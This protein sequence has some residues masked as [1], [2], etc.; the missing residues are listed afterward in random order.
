MSLT[1]SANDFFA[2]HSSPRGTTF[3][4]KSRMTSSSVMAY[5]RCCRATEVQAGNS[6]EVM[7]SAID[8]VAP[9]ASR[10]PVPW[11]LR[12][13]T[14]RDYGARLKGGPDRPAWL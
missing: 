12:E 13:A 1:N 4:R 9:T 2:V 5:K 7:V 6:S 14:H 3:A 11:R 10:G 8:A